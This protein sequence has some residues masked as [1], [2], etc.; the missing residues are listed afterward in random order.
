M[1]MSVVTLNLKDY[2]K[3]DSYKLYLPAERE[4]DVYCDRYKHML[5]TV[6]R[7][8]HEVRIYVC[9]LDFTYKDIGETPLP[10]VTLNG[11]VKSYKNFCKHLELPHL[12]D[13]PNYLVKE[14]GTYN[15]EFN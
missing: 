6:D 2:I 14:E 8:E 1:K 12:V 4:Q 13:K 3:V 7:V 10:F 5:N 11:K 9:G 15:S